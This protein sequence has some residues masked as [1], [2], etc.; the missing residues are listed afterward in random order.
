VGFL[1]DARVQ[2]AYLGVPWAG[3]GDLTAETATRLQAAGIQVAAL[4]GDPQW[5]HDP[6]LAGQWASRLGTSIKFSGVHLDIEPWTLPQ[7]T[8]KAHQ[9]LAGLATAVGR[10]RAQRPELRLEVDLAAGLATTHPAGFG[11]VL[12]AADAVTVMAYRDRSLAILEFSQSARGQLGRFQKPYRL[13]VDTLRQ[14]QQSTTFYDEGRAV[15]EEQ[16]SAV[17]QA[18]SADP[19][20]RGMAVHD[21]DGWQ[22]LRP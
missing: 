1:R 16:I 15:L 21:A 7:W 4:G 2:D 17:E 19:W 3:P 11:T 22:A 13:G 6:Q 20:F 18:L 14:P 8:E 5:A 9:L 10:V 12:Q